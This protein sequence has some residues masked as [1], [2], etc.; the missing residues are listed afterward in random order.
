MKLLHLLYSIV[1]TQHAGYFC[2]IT[3]TGPM[4]SLPK[5]HD[6]VFIT[7]GTSLDI[8]AANGEILTLTFEEA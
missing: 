5:K 3:L 2:T 6:A 4:H 7:A 1:H 8:Q